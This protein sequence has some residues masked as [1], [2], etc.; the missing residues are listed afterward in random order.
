M[1]TN[2]SIGILTQPLNNNYGGLLQNFAL[3]QVLLSL[4]HSPITLSISFPVR[5]RYY[6]FLRSLFAN[7]YKTLFLGRKLGSLIPFVPRKEDV[8]IVNKNTL[9]FIERCIKTT[10][11]L[12]ISRLNQEDFLR[13]FDSFIVGSDQVWRPSYSPRLTTFFLDFLP[14]GY[15]QKRIAYAASFGVA[16]WEYNSKKTRVCKDLVS[17]FDAIS[18]RE[19]SGVKLCKENFGVNV[20]HVLDPTLLL[21]KKSYVELTKGFERADNGRSLLV[22]VL[23]MNRDKKNI[24]DRIAKRLNLSV[25]MVMPEMK[26]SYSCKD[27]EKCIFPSVEQ[28][29][30]GFMEADFVVTDSFHGTAF[31]LVFNKP[32]V[33]IA[34]SKRGSDRFHSLL[35]S[36]NISERLIQEGTDVSNEIIDKK[37]DFDSVNRQLDLM[38]KES[39]DFLSNSLDLRSS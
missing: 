30:I 15:A 24:I 37:I 12:K 29:L 38:R 20:T 16:N 4:G 26:L 13:D 27:I 3:Q 31:S 33:S 6:Q 36:L 1:N 34:N 9:G 21:D 32:F 25:N 18:V 8:Y 28:W 11:S 22:Y 17:R 19:R 39:I 23:D 2:K 14:E 10:E 35:G 7:V 5:R